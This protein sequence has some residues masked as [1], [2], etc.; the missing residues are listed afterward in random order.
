MDEVLIFCSFFLLSRDV[1]L[2][3]PRAKD[4]GYLPKEEGSKREREPLCEG[5]GCKVQV[6]LVLSLGDGICDVERVVLLDKLQS[7]LY[8]RGNNFGGGKIK[9]IWSKM[10][11]S[12]T[13]KGLVRDKNEVIE[14]RVNF[15][16]P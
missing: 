10:R 7:L 12:I 4:S 8:S 15:R 13:T 6:S 1:V 14:E 5:E 3:I 9:I 16:A 2:P 11:N